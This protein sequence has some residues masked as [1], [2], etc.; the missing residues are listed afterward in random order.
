MQPVVKHNH[1]LKSSCTQRAKSLAY[2]HVKNK[3]NNKENKYCSS[4]TCIKFLDIPLPTHTFNRGQ[5]QAICIVKSVIIYLYQLFTL[6]ECSTYL[7]LAYYRMFTSIVSFH[8]G[9]V[10]VTYSVAFL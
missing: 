6:P 5:R 10:P 8:E 7:S 3:T 9:F 4:V 2:F 1:H